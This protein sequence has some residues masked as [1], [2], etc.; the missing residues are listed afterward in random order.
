M[1][2]SEQKSSQYVDCKQGQRYELEQ[3]GRREYP[4]APLRVT[5]ISEYL[6]RHARATSDSQ[7]EQS[8]EHELCAPECAHSRKCGKD[9]RS[10]AEDHDRDETDR[11][12]MA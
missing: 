12:R 4:P 2:R 9:A 5:L 1:C 3:S 7:Q 8:H 6:A 11:K 10:N